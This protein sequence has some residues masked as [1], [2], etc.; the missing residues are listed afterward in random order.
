MSNASPHDCFDMVIVLI[1]T[2]PSETDLTVT[3]T[4]ESFTTRPN[5]EYSCADGP[6]APLLKKPTLRFIG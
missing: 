4:V 2:T 6:I 3:G 1:S 5:V